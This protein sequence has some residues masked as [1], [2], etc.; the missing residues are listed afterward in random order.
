MILAHMHELYRTNFKLVIL[1]VS[2]NTKIPVKP[3]KRNGSLSHMS[4]KATKDTNYYFDRHS[5]E[6]LKI[7]SRLWFE[8]VPLV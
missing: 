2:S 6:F 5:N 1:N 3:Q 7:V 4:L 8:N